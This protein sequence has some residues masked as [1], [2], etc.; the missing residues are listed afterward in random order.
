MP[1]EGMGKPTAEAAAREAGV[2]AGPSRGEKLAGEAGRGLIAP[3]GWER[4][5]PAVRQSLTF[6]PRAALTRAPVI[7]R[8]QVIIGCD[9]P[10]SRAA[11]CVVNPR[12]TIDSAAS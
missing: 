3:M 6:S 9:T 10:Y 7:R 5:M 11:A 8:R 1:N 2:Q 4:I 12:A